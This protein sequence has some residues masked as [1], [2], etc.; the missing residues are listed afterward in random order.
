MTPYPG[1]KATFISDIAGERGENRR[2]KGLSSR[3]IKVAFDR[4]NHPFLILKDPLRNDF[5]IHLPLEIAHEVVTIEYGGQKF[6]DR[7]DMKE[8]E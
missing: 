5:R 1:D 3:V 4:Y 2:L 8:D 7:Y 6:F